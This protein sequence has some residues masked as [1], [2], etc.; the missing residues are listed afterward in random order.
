MSPGLSFSIGLSGDVAGAASGKWQHTS[1]TKPLPTDEQ[2]WKPFRSRAD[3]EFAEFA[4]D[5]CLNERQTNSLIAL[6]QSCIQSGEFSLKSHT[7]ICEIWDYASTKSTLVCSVWYRDLWEWGLE[8]LRDPNLAPKFTWDAEQLFKFDGSDYVRFIHE[9]W[10]A[11]RWWK[12]QT[13]LSSFGTAKGYP[14]IARCGNLPVNIRNGKGVGGGRVV[15]WLPIVDEDSGETGKKAFVNHKRVVWHEAVSLILKEVAKYSRTGFTFAC[16]DEITRILYPLILI[17]SADFEEQCVMTLTRGFGANYPCPVCLVQAEELSDLDKTYIY[18]TTATMQNVYQNA[19]SLPRAIDIEN[20]LKKYGLRN[21]DNTFWKI[22]N[23][24]P[25]LAT[26][27]DRLH[28][29]HG[30]LFSDHLWDEL[31]N[32]VK[33][34][35]KSQAKLIDNQMDQLPR[36]R[37]LNHF[38]SVTNTH[39][40]D[41]SKYED[42]SKK[43]EYAKLNPDKKWNFPKNHTHIHAP[44][45]IMAKGVTRNFNT[46]YNEKC[47]GPFKVSY[48][49]RTNYKN[50]LKIDHMCYVAGMIRDQLNELDEFH[51]YSSSNLEAFD[52]T[53]IN[54]HL[55]A[56]QT[57][58]SYSAIELRFSD[59]IAF[60]CFRLTLIDFLSNEIGT[61][62]HFKFLKVNYQ[63]K[64][65]WSTTT[66]FLRCNPSFHGAPRNDGVLIDH[67]E[68]RVLFAHL[69]FVFTCTVE[70]TIFQV[71]FVHPLDAPIGT[72][73]WRRDHDLRFIRLRAQKREASQ[74]V[75]IKSIIRG[76]P[77]TKDFGTEGDYLAMD[78]IDA[79]LSR[80]IGKIWVDSH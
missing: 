54:I 15:G 70:D 79:D 73:H 32:I 44:D 49:L 68:G 53:Q 55:G 71:A 16:A 40:T 38:K 65:D 51:K 6:F 59:D 24:D 30:G 28:A 46:K 58:T 67:G 57:S 1:N 25:Y 62:I 17:L 33:G 27:W 11:D 14:V 72:L 47:H 77:I 45:D 37:G 60:R 69:L 34:L 43:Q 26:S 20:E 61:R 23:T 41:G 4:L 5:A 48:E 21:I 80:R 31:Q 63:S 74:F 35:G 76:I 78:S 7:E 50:I 29:Y 64:I 66:D 18:R 36:W 10:T 42:I 39:F 22:A 3:F 56:Q 19:Q 75:L 2:P 9:P 52:D 13:Q 8:L 12:I